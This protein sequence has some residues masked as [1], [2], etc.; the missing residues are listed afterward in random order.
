MVLE[1]KPELILQIM[2]KGSKTTK[3]MKGSKNR[4]GLAQVKA[5]F[6]HINKQE[7]LNLII[8]T[9]RKSTIKNIFSGCVVRSEHHIEMLN[10]KS[11]GKEY[12][13]VLIT[14]PFL[15]GIQ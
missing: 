15:F 9:T 1:L 5:I 10:T 12:L 14:E 3:I 13:N 4:R 8:I 2:L 7:M 6:L 11:I